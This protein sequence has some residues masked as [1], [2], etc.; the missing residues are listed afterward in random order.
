MRSKLAYRKKKPNKKPWCV[1]AAA[2]LLLLAAGIALGVLKPE[3]KPRDEGKLAVHFLDV[4]QGDAVFIAFPDGKT[5]LVDA[6]EEG[7][8]SGIVNYIKRAGY[9]HIDCLV[10]THPHSDHIGGMAYVIRNMDV[11]AVYMPAVTTTTECF[12]NLLFAVQEKGLRVKKGEAGV[13]PINADG[14]SAEIIAPVTLDGDNLNNS[15]VVLRITYRSNS[16]LLSGD[17]GTDEM[18]SI[19]GDISADVL[20]VGHHGSSSATDQAL[21]QRISPQIAVISCGSNN[22]YGHPHREVLRDLKKAGCEVYRTDRD[23]TVIITSDGSE[24]A[25]R[26][27]GSIWRNTE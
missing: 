27:A 5:M 11:K 4:G 6:G 13:K 8:G 22:E 25:V 24:L 18:D 16:F 19:V 26:T 21:L 23:N 1:L 9:E 14:V 7:C 3:R 15:S 2:A 20:K 10:A 12:E 17:A